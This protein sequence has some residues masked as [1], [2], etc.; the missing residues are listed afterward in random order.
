[1]ERRWR[2]REKER[3]KER[4]SVCVCVCMCVCVC[5]DQP[6]CWARSV[7]LSP[8][9]F[10]DAAIAP[11]D[12]PTAPAH[13]IPR[14][15]AAAGVKVSD[16]AMWEINEAFSVVALANM[17]V[18][19]WL[20]PHLLALLSPSDSCLHDCHTFAFAYRHRSSFLTFLLMFLRFLAWRTI[21]LT[22]TVAP[23][24]SGIPLGGHLYPII[25][26][27]MYPHLYLFVIYNC[28]APC[29]LLYVYVHLCTYIRRLTNIYI[30]RACPHSQMHI[31][32]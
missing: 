4:E 18:P 11:I 2:K 20:P 25:D 27:I 26:P 23:S 28:H 31:Y 1:M 13:A 24:L 17:K 7:P 12:F 16:I 5:I 15:L 32:I 10:A 21:K 22:S 14:A 3:K 8:S 9:G 6:R 19:L 29:S 30:L